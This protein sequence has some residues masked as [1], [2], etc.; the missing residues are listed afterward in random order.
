MQVLSSWMHPSCRF[1]VF[2]TFPRLL[3]DTPSVYFSVL[4]SPRRRRHCSTH[5]IASKFCT[6]LLRIPNS[7]FFPFS[8][9]FGRL[10][11]PCRSS[12]TP[13]G[14][15]CVGRRITCS[16][17]LRRRVGAPFANRCQ[18]ARGVGGTNVHVQPS[19]A[20]RV[21]NRP[22]PGANVASSPFTPAQQPRRMRDSLEL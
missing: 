14:D 13:F 11:P 6:P 3:V 15:P 9:L 22:D 19:V 7:H 12:P 1:P 8:L 2:T 20:H 4:L 16:S 18:Q 17:P 5:S 21:A 10:S